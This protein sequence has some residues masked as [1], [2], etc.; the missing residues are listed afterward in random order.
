[1]ELLPLLHIRNGDL[2]EGTP[3]HWSPMAKPYPDGGSDVAGLARHLFVRFG[4]VAIVDLGTGRTEDP[5]H[6]LYQKLARQHVELW[7]DAFPEKMEDVLDLFV[8]G[9]QRVTARVDRMDLDDLSEVLEMAEGEVWLGYPFRTLPELGA[10]VDEVDALSFLDAGAA[11]VLLIDLGAAGRATGFDAR[12]LEKVPHD[13][14][15]VYAS[16][17]IATPDQ[18]VRL[19]EAGAAGALVGTA[20]L[21]DV[22]GFAALAKALKGEDE[23][24]DGEAVLD[25][26]APRF[27]PTRGG[28][29]I[30]PGVLPER[31]RP[32]MERP[33][34]EEE[35]A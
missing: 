18:V 16:G 20:L 4:A 15:P 3:D 26:E 29:S 14:G 11:G 13:D 10:L 22:A 19:E 25:P 27:A 24:E 12:A 17:G 33:P 7:A 30:L 8:S 6:N 28:R 32:E 2:V 5:D 1:M 21:R 23:K 9:A 34:R 35:G 31:G